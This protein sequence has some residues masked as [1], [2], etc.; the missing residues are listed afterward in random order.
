M[1]AGVP[2]RDADVAQAA[3]IARDL[4]EPGIRI[5]GLVEIRHDHLDELSGKADH[6]LVLG[7]HAR[8]GLRDLPA[9]IDGEPERQQQRQQEVDAPAQ[10]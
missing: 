8:P 6:A 9:D 3:E 2:K 5:G 10:G 1:A 7:L 4:V